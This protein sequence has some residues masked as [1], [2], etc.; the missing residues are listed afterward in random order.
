M[1][2]QVVY[3]SKTMS[4][5]YGY[6]T[7]GFLVMNISQEDYNRDDNWHVDNCERLGFSYQPE[8]NNGR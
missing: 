1:K 6:F 4:G 8:E 7:G 5:I 3:K 2:K